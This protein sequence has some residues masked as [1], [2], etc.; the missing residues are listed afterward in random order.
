[1]V[2]F[3]DWQALNNSTFPEVLLYRPD[4]CNDHILLN[5]TIQSLKFSYHS[6]FRFQE[7]KIILKNST[8]WQ[9]DPE[10]ISFKHLYFSMHFYRNSSLFPTQFAG[11][12]PCYTLHIM[13]QGVKQIDRSW[14]ITIVLGF[15]MKES[16]VHTGR[17]N[18][19]MFALWAFMLGG[20]EVHL[21]QQILYT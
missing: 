9:F 15:C 5:I 1:M 11:I 21:A 7:G 8:F 3:M 16:I 18:I 17:V 2:L 20:F 19:K 12:S 4:K 10:I 14:I 6:V 13:M